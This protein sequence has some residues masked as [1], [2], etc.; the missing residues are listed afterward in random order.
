MDLIATPEA[1]L[2]GLFLASFLAATLLP[3]GSEVA[4]VAF[5]TVHP[6]QSIAAL[7]LATLGNTLGGLTTYGM[8]RLIPFKVGT[9][10]TANFSGRHAAMLY[11]WGPAALLLSWAP[12]VGD[13]LCAA[14]GW[15]RLPL[16]P[17]VLW[18][19]AG[20]AARYGVLAALTLYFNG[21]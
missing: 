6:E 1:G 13:A 2:L 21:S 16:L 9:D 14:A 7:L 3:G 12:L 8:G 15:L 19:A 5:L 20:K 17:C 4:L 11:R 18:M 10:G